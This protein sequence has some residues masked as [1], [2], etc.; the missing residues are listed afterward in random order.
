MS[1]N[2]CDAIVIH[3]MDFRLQKFLNDWLEQRLGTRNYDRV[4]LAG[5]AFDIETVTKQAEASKR[6]HRIKKILL[7]NHEGCGAYGEKG[8]HERH[9]ADLA[10]AEQSDYSAFPG[11]V[12]EKYYLRVHGIFEQIT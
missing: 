1:D 6:L 8:T 4:G 10:R 12:I 2:M 11:L 7:I 3:C 5:G 9:K